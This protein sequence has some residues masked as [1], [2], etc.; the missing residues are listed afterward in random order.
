MS[1]QGVKQTLTLAALKR[2]LT[3]TYL[4]K[5]PMLIKKIEGI[6]YEYHLYLTTNGLEGRQVIPTEY[7]R[8]PVPFSAIIDVYHLTHTKLDKLYKELNEQ[9]GS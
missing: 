4:V 7:V 9:T 1:R 2:L 5:E 3:L 8:R 6:M